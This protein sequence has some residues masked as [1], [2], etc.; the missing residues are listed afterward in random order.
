MF[1]ELLENLTAESWQEFQ[2]KSPATARA[3]VN[4][5]QFRPLILPLKEQAE[6]AKEQAKLA[7]LEALRHY[8]EAY[9]NGGTFTISGKQYDFIEVV[10]IALNSLTFRKFNKLQP[11]RYDAHKA[12]YPA[13]YARK[14]EAV[15]ILQG[16]RDYKGRTNLDENGD[17][18]PDGESRFVFS[19]TAEKLRPLV[20]ANLSK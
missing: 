11:G 13:I 12:E 19:I 5:P 18:L 2:A 7:E 20:E 14:E 15:K 4:D 1:A 9:D 17:V 6:K 8:A 3:M 10:E 16:I